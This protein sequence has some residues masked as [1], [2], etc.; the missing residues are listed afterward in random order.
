MIESGGPSTRVWALTAV[1]A[2][3]T[4]LLGSAPTFL[5]GGLATFAL[6]ALHMSRQLLGIAVA[7]F[8][9][10]SAVFSY[11]GGHI[12]DRMLPR[13]AMTLA[14]SI[15][16]VA[17]LSIATFVRT[18]PELIVALVIAG[19]SNGLGHPASNSAIAVNVPT[20]RRALTLGMKQAAIPMTSVLAGLAVPAI[21]LTV[22]WRWSFVAVAALGVVLVAVTPI[23]RRDHVGSMKASGGR[24]GLDM[25][26]LLLIAL[27][28][29]LGSAGATALG[30]FL[31]E[32]LTHS[33]FSPTAAG[34][35]LAA[36]NFAGVTIRIIL[37][38]SADRYGLS[39]FPLMAGLLIIAS[40]SYL[41]LGYAGVTAALA[42]AAV[43]AAFGGNGWQGLF[44]YGVV[45][46]AGGS[47]AVATGIAQ[48]GVYIGAMAG[49]VMFGFV[50]VGVG[51]GAAWSLV[52]ITSGLGGLLLIGITLSP[53]RKQLR[54]APT[55]VRAEALVP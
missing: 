25:R 36:G 44:Q 24:Q 50:S 31:V 46:Q 2:V 54:S 7:S 38:W 47:P 35:L 40:G 39:P 28:G 55:D 30:S 21:A 32:S 4:T 51:F 19:I 27:A 23:A 53:G 6:P 42:V 13:Q 11:F 26:R 52:A 9:A 10:A 37:G 1:G 45:Q 17:T 8:F 49:P 41:A 22:G 16:V 5:I 29:L 15:S 18:A 12:S 48:S 43:T 20:R 14:A 34:A 3:G 33:H